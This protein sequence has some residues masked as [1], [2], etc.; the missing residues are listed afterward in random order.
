MGSWLA[1]MK[2]KAL[3]LAKP[4]SEVNKISDAEFYAST[5]AGQFIMRG[6]HL[7]GAKAANHHFKSGIA[8]SGDRFTLHY[9]AEGL[10]K[11]ADVFA[12]NKV[13]DND[14]S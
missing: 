9:Y 13:T 2:E 3:Y 14:R 10:N 5:R 7:N 8:P 6:L 4:K 12:K 11:L 1:D